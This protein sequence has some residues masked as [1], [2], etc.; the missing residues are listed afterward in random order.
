[1]SEPCDN[2]LM[3]EWLESSLNDC[4]GHRTCKTRIGQTECVECK[5]RM[6][7]PG[8]SDEDIIAGPWTRLLWSQ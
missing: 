3:T 5:L 1:M 2:T 6:L 4:I 8:V 7:R